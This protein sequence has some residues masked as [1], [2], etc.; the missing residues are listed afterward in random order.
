MCLRKW[1]GNEKHEENVSSA[2]KIAKIEHNRKE[3]SAVLQKSHVSSMFE[4]NE[5][6]ES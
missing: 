2:L 1:K 4:G 5:E 3:E 6:K